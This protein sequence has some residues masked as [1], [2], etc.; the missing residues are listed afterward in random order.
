[1][2]KEL[3]AAME[4]IMQQREKRASK[5]D[6]PAEPLRHSPVKLTAEQ[7]T[8]R[9]LEESSSQAFDSSPQKNGDR[10]TTC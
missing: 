7:Y 6:M 4:Q 5:L 8:L 10:P 9:F 2:E 1:M 3:A